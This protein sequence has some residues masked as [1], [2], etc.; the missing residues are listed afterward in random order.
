MQDRQ[1]NTWCVYIY[2]YVLM[3]AKYPSV[4]TAKVRARET[5][6][7][8]EGRRC[9]CMHATN[10]DEHKTTYPSVK[11]T[12]LPALAVIHDYLPR[13]GCSFNHAVSCVFLHTVCSLVSQIRGNQYAWRRVCHIHLLNVDRYGKPE[14]YL[15]HCCILCIYSRILQVECTN[16]PQVQITSM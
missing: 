15:Q 10:G 5:R 14:E 4:L 3:A 9:R 12:Q 11:L 1:R 2:I 16:R 13:H 8:V 7:I 6:H